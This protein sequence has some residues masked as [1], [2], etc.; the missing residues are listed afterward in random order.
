MGI[1]TTD[2]LPSSVYVI[3]IDE[4][5][6]KLARNVDDALLTIPKALNITSVGI[7]SSHLFT[8]QKQNVK[9]FIFIDNVIQTPVVPSATTTNLSQDLLT[10]DD[11][12]YA[13][14][15]TNFFIGEL[16]SI[17]NEVMKIESIGIGSTNA[18]RLLRPWLGTEIANHS[19]G[20]TITKISGNYSIVGNK[21]HF[22]E[23][24]YGNVPVGSP[25]NPPDERDWK[26]ISTY[27][28]FQGRTFM[29]SGIKDTSN[30]SYYRNFIFDDISSEFDGIENTFTLTTNGNN[31]TDIVDENGI[32]LVNNI[33]QYPG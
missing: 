1:G 16:I 28:T 19:I 10:I 7:G 15:T 14:S 29:R 30:E 18:I 20:S 17:N 2:K 5:N 26:D 3:K 22:A 31:I 25:S 12:L 21:I 11:V 13:N 27:S 6:I 8:S 33:F 23:A 24:P 4:N 9:S 32:V